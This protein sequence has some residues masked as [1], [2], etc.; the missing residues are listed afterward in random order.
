MTGIIPTSGRE[1]GRTI[2]SRQVTHVCIEHVRFDERLGDDVLNRRETTSTIRAAAEAFIEG[3]RRFRARFAI[4]GSA[5]FRV[6][7][8]V[9][10]AYDHW[11]TEISIRVANRWGRVS[12]KAKAKPMPYWRSRLSD[13]VNDAT[14]SAGT[15]RSLHPILSRSKCSQEDYNHSKLKAGHFWFKRV[16]E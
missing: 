15:G 1:A 10:R 13:I 14:T 7:K 4:E 6:R 16:Q 11:G 9:A 8:N 3:A 12:A 5:D 2:V